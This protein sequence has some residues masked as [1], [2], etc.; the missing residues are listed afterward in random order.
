M[1]YTKMTVAQALVKFLDNQYV[2][3]DGEVTKFVEGVLVRPWMRI[4]EA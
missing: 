4:Q 1:G 2:E 3:R